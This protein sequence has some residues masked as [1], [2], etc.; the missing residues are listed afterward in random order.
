GGI[1]PTRRRAT[2]LLRGPSFPTTRAR[3]RRNPPRC[4]PPPCASDGCSSVARGRDTPAPRA[5]P[6]PGSEA[7]RCQ[8]QIAS[9]SRRVPSYGVRSCTLEEA[10]R[11]RGTTPP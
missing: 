10:G 7:A 6:P 2:A 11:L 5:L 8:G 4:P 9:R 1:L 3:A